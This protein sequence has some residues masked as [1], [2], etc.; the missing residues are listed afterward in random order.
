MLQHGLKSQRLTEYNYIDLY[1]KHTEN[2][3]QPDC[4]TNR[5]QDI[6]MGWV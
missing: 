5:T 2:F 1:I 6:G 3:V 4:E